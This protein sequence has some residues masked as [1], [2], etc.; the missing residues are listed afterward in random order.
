MSILIENISKTFG[1][2][3][4]LHQVNLEIKDGSLVALLGPSGSGKSTLLRLLAGFEQPDSGRIW[5]NGQDTTNVQLQKREIGFVFQ[6]YALFPY[7]TVW[8]NI[9]FGLDIREIEFSIK[10]KRVNELLQLMQLENFASYY[11]HQ[12]S[13][14]QRQRVAL[15]RALAVEPKVLLLDEPFSA[16]DTKIRK[17]LRNWLR[18]L[19]QNIAVTTL[20]VT[21]DHI[22]AFELANEIVVLDNGSI[23]QIG[24]PQEIFFKL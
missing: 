24:T 11:P 6:N 19:H 7:L 4:A 15:A 10:Q 2:F 9:A 14:G 16:L 8:D 23:I 20:F 18:N 21:H 1:T 5:L 12:L 3:K 13:G 17:Q 22:E